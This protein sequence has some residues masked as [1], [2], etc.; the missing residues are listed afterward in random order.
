MSIDDTVEQTADIAELTTADL[1]LS[2][3]I[4]NAID[5]QF[6]DENNKE[7]PAEADLK[8][9]P[10]VETETSEDEQDK[11]ADVQPLDPPSRWSD[12][13]KEMFAKQPR[14][15]Q[16]FLLNRSKDMEAD[17]TRKTQELSETRRAIEPMLNE[18]NQWEPYLKS[19]GVAPS[20]AFSNLLANDQIL[21]TGTVEQKYQAAAQLAQDYG[22]DLAALAHFGETL[23]KVDPII[24]QLRQEVYDL[25]GFVGQQKQQTVAARESAVVSEI[26]GFISAKDATGNLK[27]PHFERVEP[28]MAKLIKDGTAR[29]LNEA[30]EKALRLD[31]ELYQETLKRERERMF[32]E[33]E[34]SR[35]EALEKAKRA[36]SV[37]AGS[38]MPKGSATGGD[39][40]DLLSKAFASHGI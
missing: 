11:P 12:A 16:E 27:H 33:N 6:S 36:T 26:E 3:I 5:E 38:S 13:D 17:Y 37:K 9:E 8:E 21:R 28:T 23:P 14:E 15:T 32:T 22:L 24:S 29:D 35:K 20:V 34:K 31:D 7:L 39:L 30:Y 25:K 19:V 4:E 1:D 2:T 10:S 40:D 18:V